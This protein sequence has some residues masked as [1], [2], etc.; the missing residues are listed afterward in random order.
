MILISSSVNFGASAPAQARYA[1]IERPF[2]ERETRGELHAH[3]L[4]LDGDLATLVAHDHDLVELV[5]R[6][7]MADTVSQ[8]LREVARVLAEGLRGLSRLPAAVPVLECLGQ[9]PVIQRQ[10][11][12]D[13]SGQQRVD[14]PAVEIEPL[15]IGLP[16]ALRK[17]ARPRDGEA[18]GVGAQL[19]HQLDV[20]L[21]AVA[22]IVGDVAGVAVGD[23]PGRVRVS[24]P[25]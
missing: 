25:D 13:A 17:D 16:R 10:E 12:L 5:D 4:P 18:V 6:E 20:L 23:L 9:I 1:L 8:L 3:H 21:V 19:L 7:E 24:I 2:R 15:R 14:E 22:V 11:R